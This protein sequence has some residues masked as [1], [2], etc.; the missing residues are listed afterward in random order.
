MRKTLIISISFLPLAVVFLGLVVC[1]NIYLTFFFYHII[2]CLAVPIILFIIRKV[3]LKSILNN[4]GIIRQNALRS[5][6]AGMLSG[7]LFFVVII[8]I[9]YIYRDFLIDANAIKNLLT[10]W[11]FNNSHII[12]FLIYFIFF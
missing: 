4:I 3:G 10:S 8:V 2:V 9:F 7:I 11:E 5:S 12:F 1:K 6:A